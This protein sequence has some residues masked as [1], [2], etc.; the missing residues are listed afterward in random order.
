MITA[1]LFIII[2][3]TSYFY[4]LKK[5]PFWGLFAYVVI[6][7]N[8][9]DTDINW[10]FVYVPDLRWSLLSAIILLISTVIHRDKLSTHKFSYGYWVFIFYILTQIITLTIAV[11][12][13]NASIHS[14]Y[15]LTYSIAVYFFIKSIANFNQLRLLILTIIGLAANLGIV[16]IFEGKLVRDRLEN[17][18]PADAYSSNE[19]GVLLAAIIPL[20][21]PYLFRGRK[22]EKVICLLSLPLLIST[23]IKCASRGAFVSFVFSI[24]YVFFLIA[25]NKVRKYLLIGAILFL[26]VF[27]IIANQSFRSRMATLWELDDKSSHASMNK[28]S[29]G[30]TGIW[31]DGLRM[32][33]DYP[34]GAGPDGFRALS[35]FYVTFMASS[36]RSS[37][38]GYEYKVRAA[39]NSYLQVLVEQGYLGFCVFMI[40][41]FGTLR[42]LYQST[43]KIKRLGRYGTFIDL[44]IVG[45]NMSFMVSVMGGI[46]G[47]QVYYEFFWWQVAL[48]IV[49]SSFVRN[50][51]E[52]CFQY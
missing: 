1:L 33:N 35:R 25:N 6:Y 40:I 46:F 51:T 45:L 28:L 9:P 38:L 26:P 34:L 42:L 13:I 36:E 49:A 41:C 19:L 30:R 23:F 14:Y 29:T 24:V 2:N 47:A 3:F 4:A 10:W 50:K 22:H 12:P 32:V 43:K 21:L 18:G 44:F 20:I 27:M 37:S 8:A 31:R 52:D 16:A 39:H 17:I 48:S 11:D 5:G 7:F 15:M